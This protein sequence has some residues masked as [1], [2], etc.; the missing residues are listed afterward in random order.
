[1]EESVVSVDMEA[2]VRNSVDY[3]DDIIIIQYEAIT[4]TIYVYYF[5]YYDSNKAFLAY[6]NA[7]YLNFKVYN[8]EALAPIKAAC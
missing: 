1:M 5:I 3:F 6:F 8:V 2:F 7:N 4:T